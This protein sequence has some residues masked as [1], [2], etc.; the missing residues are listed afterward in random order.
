MVYR[1]TLVKAAGASSAEIVGFTP[2]SCRHP[3]DMWLKDVHIVNSYP[4]A[5]IRNFDKCQGHPITLDNVTFEGMPVEQFG[6]IV[7][8]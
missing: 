7:K 2:E 4:R 1:S 3:G 5:D 6:Y 8:R